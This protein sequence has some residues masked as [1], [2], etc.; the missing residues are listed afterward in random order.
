MKFLKKFL[1]VAFTVVLGAAFGVTFASC[2]NDNPPTSSAGETSD[3]AEYVYRVSVQNETGFGFKNATV[4]LYDGDKQIASKK[5]NSN[6][7]ANF[8]KEEV[9]T[10]GNYTIKVNDTPVGYEPVSEEEVKTVAAEKTDTVFAI[11]PTGVIKADA[12][13]NT[14]YK[15][16]DVM[17]DFTGTNCDG[18]TFTLSEVLKTKQLVLINFWATWCG[19]CKSEFPAMHNAASL[20]TD[21]V[22]V[23]A[24]STTDSQND[25]RNFRNSY[26][27]TAFDMAANSQIDNGALHAQFGVSGIPRS[28]LV[29]RY[30][31]IVFDHTGSMTATSDFT[32]RFDRFIE[33]EYKSLIMG[34]PTTDDDDEQGGSGNELVG[35]T[36]DV[37]NKKPSLTDVKTALK[38]DDG[39]TYRWQADG[40]EVGSDEYDAYSWPWL[41]SDNKDYIYAPNA[42]I[43]NS[44]ATLYVDFTAADNT[45][46]CFDYKL[47]SEDN[48]DILYV[49]IDGVPIQK[50]SGNHLKNWETCYAYV[51]EEGQGGKH[52]MT[53]L[54]LKD[55]ETT[56]YEDVVQIKS[57][58]FKNLSDIENDPTVDANVFRYA[59]T[60]R[61][62]DENA[63]TQFKNYVSVAY[64]EED[65]YYHVGT[66]D[67]PILFANMMLASEWNA[68]SVWLLAYDNLVVDDYGNYKDRIENY[69]WEA[70]NNMQMLGYTPVTEELRQLLDVVVSVVD[71]GRKFDG[72]Y[73]ENEWL[74]LCIYYQHYGATPQMEDPM[75]GISFTGAIAMQEG[76]NA[77]SVPF[78][79]NPR[80]FKYKFIPTRSGA[81][82]VYSTGDYDT[83]VFLTTRE[84]VEE[85]KYNGGNQQFLG[86]WDDK[87]FPEDRADDADGNFEFYW[88]FEEGK[89]YYMLFTTFLDVAANYNV[90][91]QYVE[92]GEVLTPAATSNSANIETGEEF[93]PDAIDYVYDEA[94]D[95]YR[96]KNADG[97]MGGKIY[98]DVKHTTFFFRENAIYYTLEA[99]LKAGNGVIPQN[100]NPFYLNGV[101]YSMILWK[102]AYSA[103]QN[104]GDLNGF[105][106]VNK[107]LYETLYAITTSNVYDGIEDSWLL[108][109]YYMRELA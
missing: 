26:D 43:H 88:Y 35:P 75:K 36:A 107:E 45:V 85:A 106:E 38:G 5:T 40:A 59:A 63:K 6:G 42:N 31:V 23:L 17:Y 102:Y 29:D 37:L 109:C 92:K 32:S 105:V 25:V 71:F 7:N 84:L 62:T 19:P 80:G 77:V 50:L 55:T 96:K 86:S 79:I 53:L 34:A 8:L 93:I 67:G 78:A 48:A 100:K 60:V 73:H 2:N 18:E 9:P 33:D 94:N 57:L 15:L 76:D 101:D 14:R 51:F 81:Y 39:F 21:S 22:A 30:G 72:E 58:Y 82:K 64:N 91:I 56:A 13:D 61:N 98:L 46:L 97:S 1:I 87:I 28:F 99:L 70:N 41:L 95:V 24:I 66:K 104:E 10:V 11:R 74:E 44:Y 65:E 4:S 47:G 103:M 108:L 20:Y 49:L 52:E 27:Y 16:G 3:T 69:A 83:F 54:Y 90:T 68:T 89:T 12:P